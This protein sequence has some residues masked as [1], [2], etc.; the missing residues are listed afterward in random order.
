MTSNSTLVLNASFEPLNIIS[1]ERAIQLLFQGKVEVLEE[2]GTEV[3]SVTQTIRVPAVLR[4]LKFIPLANRQQTVRFSRANVF[5]RDKFRCQ[6]C[7]KR[8]PK[9]QL[10]LDH[11]IPVVQGGKKTWENIVTSCRPCNQK[12]GGRTP[13]QAGFTLVKKPKRPTWLSHGQLPTYAAVLPE[14]WQI[15]LTNFKDYP[16]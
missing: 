8:Y 12:K 10:T 5:L 11:V 7:E 3:R 9:T 1:W 15:Y 16:T 13:K 2:S 6:Y 4:L 14:I